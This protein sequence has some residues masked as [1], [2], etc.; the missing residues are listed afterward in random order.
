MFQQNGQTHAQKLAADLAQ[1]FN[2]CLIILW[3]LGIIQ[4]SAAIV[5]QIIKLSAANV[6]QIIKL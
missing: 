5:F 1:L 6:F 4:L 3:T 2:V